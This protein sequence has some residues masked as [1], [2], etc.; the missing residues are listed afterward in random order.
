MSVCTALWAAHSARRALTTCKSHTRAQLAT[1]ILD[2]L[3]ESVYEFITA[4]GDPVHLFEFV[5]DELQSHAETARLRE[6]EGKYAG[7]IAYIG[8]MERLTS[9]N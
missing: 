6:N 3:T 4:M 2:D 1:K 9:N 5:E 8:N 7:I